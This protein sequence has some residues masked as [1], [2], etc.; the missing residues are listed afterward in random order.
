MGSKK[1]SGGY[2][3]GSGAKPK[4]KE[5]TTTIAFRVPKSKVNE[6]KDLVNLKLSE[7]KL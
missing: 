2:R 7:Y 3:Q 6:L 4:Y 1:K 5:Q